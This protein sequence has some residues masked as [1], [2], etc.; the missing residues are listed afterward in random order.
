MRRLI[1]DPE[2]RERLGAA[3][4]ARQAELYTP[5]T[6]IPQYEQAYELALERRRSRST[7]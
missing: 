2:L 3:A 1:D 4:N 6:V 7:E 5:D